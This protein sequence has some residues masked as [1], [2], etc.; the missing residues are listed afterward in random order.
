MEYLIT[1][2]NHPNYGALID[3][4]NF[5]CADEDPVQAVSRLA[6]L[7]FHVHAKDFKYKRFDGTAPPEGW[8]ATRGQ[9]YICGTIVGQG[10]IPVAQCLK[11]LNKA[12]Y[13]EGL[14]LEFEG[15]EDNMTALVEGY[16]YL[17]KIIGELEG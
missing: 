13:N 7:A 17:K 4:G 6:P 11:I 15:R 14:G 5:I 10:D 3:I 16:N 12:G 1:A 9:N 2:V 8:G